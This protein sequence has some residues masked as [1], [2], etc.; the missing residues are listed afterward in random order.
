[1]NLGMTNT[2]LGVLANAV[3][4]YAIKRDIDIFLKKEEC[5][6]KNIWILY[7]VAC[8]WTSFIYELFKSP[9]WNVLANLSGL[10]LVIF[11]YKVKLSRKFLLIF[12]I[13]IVNVLADSIVV[14]SFTKYVIGESINQVYGCI[15]SL[16]ILL[17]AYILEKTIS[18]EHDKELPVLYRIVLGLVPVISIVYIYC[19]GMTA[20]VPK[21]ILFVVS[22]GTLFI[23]ILIFYLYDS[24]VKFYSECIEKKIFEQMV[25]VYEYQ[26]NLV[27]ESQE[28]VNALRHDM[29]H[30]IIELSALANE[31]PQVIQYLQ[32]M[33]KFMLNPKECVATGNKEID[34]ILNY[35]LQDVD[36]ELNRADIKLNIP[37]NADWI[38]FNVCVVLGNLVDNA[39]RESKKSEKK[40]LDIKITLK[41]GIMLI[42]IVNSYSGEIVEKDH[43]FKTS[44]KDFA[45]H[46]VGIENVKK[47]VEL[48]GGEMSIDYEKDFFKVK[49]LLY[50]F[51]IKQQF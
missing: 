32:E 11:P 2:I 20:S 39:V 13:Y 36:K 18:I 5:G 51:G 48:N 41:K 7:C 9:T 1:M 24:L 34:S 21:I 23:N 49:V 19:M 15:T 47:I 46:G 12:M 28:Q 27:Q 17:I 4:F 43:R 38:D 42:D 8:C 35:L 37:K 40:Y 50:L 29:K 45:I 44:Q 3:R 16:V 33:R 26:L 31:N 14:L 6:W 25:E 30:H 22:A 10:M